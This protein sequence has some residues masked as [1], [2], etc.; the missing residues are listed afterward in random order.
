MLFKKFLF[1]YISSEDF[2]ESITSF[3]ACTNENFNSTTFF[4]AYTNI[5]Y[6]FIIVVKVLLFVDMKISY[7]LSQRFEFNKNLIR[8]S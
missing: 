6:L 4:D 5:I 2:N 1:L 3:N 7:A 8:D